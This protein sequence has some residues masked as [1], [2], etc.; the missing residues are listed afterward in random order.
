MKDKKAETVEDVFQR[1]IFWSSIFWQ[2]Q[3]RLMGLGRMDKLLN[4]IEFKGS[5]EELKSLIKDFYITMHKYYL[6]KSNN[7]IGDTG[8]II[9]L[10]GLE[11]NNSYFCNKYTYAFI[12][13]L[14]E[15]PLPD[16]KNF[17]KSS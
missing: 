9:I 10:G 12:E 14:K 3:H 1:I 5:N 2:S 11:N 15:Q 17:I 4:N 6:F 13:A 8:Q 16:P 7:L